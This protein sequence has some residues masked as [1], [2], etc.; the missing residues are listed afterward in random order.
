MSGAF[1]ARR[2]NWK[3]VGIVALAAALAAGLVP[4]TAEGTEHEPAN[5]VDAG[6]ILL[7]TGPNASEN[8]IRYYADPVE[9]AVGQSFTA[10][11][12][13]PTAEQTLDVNSRCTVTS[14]DSILEI[15]QTGGKRV[16]MVSNGLGVGAK[17]NCSTKEGRV[18]ETQTLTFS[19]SS[20]TFGSSVFVE[21]IEVDAEGK[22][23][24]DL[25]WTVS[26]GTDTEAGFE[27]LV[28]SS[29]NGPDS[30][31]NDNEIATVDP[32]LLFKEVTF[33]PTG[34]EVAIE[35]GGDGPIPGGDLR[36]FYGVNQTLFKLVEVFDGVLD[37]AV[38]E[39]DSDGPSA[40]IDPDGPAETIT[41][42]RGENKDATDC[43]LLLYNFRIEN[44]A[45]LFDA[46]FDFQDT[47][48]FLVRIDWKPGS[49]D[50]LNPPVREIDFGDGVWVTRPDC[51]GL[52]D[53]GDYESELPDFD[54]E[55]V[56]PVDAP[57]CLA[58][59]LWVQLGNGDWQ[60]IQFY[61]G[62]DDPRWR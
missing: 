11:N 10:A 45:V 2:A 36:G 43:E 9:P 56:H 49:Y 51:D 31:V 3:V 54:D 38:D 15:S 41:L 60:Q 28:L 4:T 30:G 47:A 44:Q 7:S 18:D 39:D 14:D 50:P 12:L 21:S 59:E 17:N 35:G 27:G 24:T 13:T 40:T 52:F 32:D 48:T 1:L 22:F 34:S 23:G 5:V 8:W 16:A 55:Y 46:N 42:W 57:F 58:G 29:D 6:V 26:D 25:Q 20:G 62:G 37:C 33:E 53:E 61:D 19:L